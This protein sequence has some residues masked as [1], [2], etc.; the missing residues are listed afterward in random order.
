VRPARRRIADRRRIAAVSLAILAHVALFSLLLSGTGRLPFQ[1]IWREQPTEVWLAPRLLVR[2]PPPQR[3]PPESR[4]AP[5]SRA[6]AAATPSS[7]PPA[8][9]QAPSQAPGPSAPGVASPVAPSP[10][11]GAALR[12]WVG[13]AQPDAAW[14]SDADRARCRERLAAGAANAPHLEGMPA[15][16]LAYFT[17][18]AKAQAEW[19]SS[20]DPGHGLGIGCVSYFGPGVRPKPPPHA[21]KLGPCVIAPPRGSLDVDVDILPD[22]ETAK[23]PPDSF[24][25]RHG[26]LSRVAG[27]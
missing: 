23:P 12:G 5:S 19:L 25:T 6:H 21:L 24:T 4:A 13:C 16:K 2:P 11:V 17:A 20:P 9:S 3:R 27:Q 1:P 15:T 7:G 22:G 8:L 10:G 18:V 26:P 14:M